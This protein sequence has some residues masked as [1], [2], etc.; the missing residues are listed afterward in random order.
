[1]TASGCR[2]MQNDVPRASRI[3]TKWRLPP[4]VGFNS[5]PHPNTS[6]GPGLLGQR[7]SD[8]ECAGPA[9]P[10]QP[11]YRNANSEHEPLRLAIGQS[12]TAQPGIAAGSRR[13]TSNATAGLQ[14]VIRY[15]RS[16]NRDRSGRRSDE[17]RACHVIAATTSGSGQLT[18]PYLAILSRMTTAW[19]S[20]SR[21]ANSLRV[22]GR[23]GEITLET[24][25]RSI[26]IPAIPH[27]V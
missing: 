10:V 16:A 4:P 20:S 8:A 21:P 24:A 26:S 9:A 13:P 5:D 15:G 12:A 2:S 6:I 14:P 11:Q 27:A 19:R 1:M 17:A 7:P 3:S 23:R 22:P 18:M 25:V